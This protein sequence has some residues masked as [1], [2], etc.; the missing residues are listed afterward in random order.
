MEKESSLLTKS[1]FVFIILT[2]FSCATLPKP[3]DEKIT[4]TAQRLA[5]GKYLVE[6]IGV[7]GG[8]HTPGSHEGKPLKEKHLAG[9]LIFIEGLGTINIPNI[10]P[11]VQTGI[12]GWTDGE[13]IRAMREGVNKKGE[14]MFPFM[15]YPN[16]RDMSDDDVKAMVAYLRTV[17]PVSNKVPKFK[18]PFPVNIMFWLFSPTP[19]PVK[20]VP[21]P[22]KDDPVVLGKYLVTIGACS[23]CHTPRKGM[24]QDMSRFMAGGDPHKGY[25]GTTYASN[26]TPD[27]DTGIGNKTDEE[28]ITILRK[29]ISRPPM[30]FLS[31]YYKRVTDNDLKAAVA[32]L[33]SIP[34]IKNNVPEPKPYPDKK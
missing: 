22:P 31:S 33:R 18:L 12:G 10:T 26:I 16:Y 5:R 34:A 19:K 21:N 32:Y 8:C 28:I 9:D 29:G 13:I 3:S 14:I 1:I 23:D 30:S 15:P 2:S 24:K 20:D 27:K 4:L 17:P 7:C 25:W 6:G 11:D